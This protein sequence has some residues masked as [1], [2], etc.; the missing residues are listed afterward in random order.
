MH[1]AHP[2]PTVVITKTVTVPAPAPAPSPS[3]TATGTGAASTTSNGTTVAFYSFTMTANYTT[4]LGTTKPTQALMAS[5][6]S[7]ASYDLEFSSE[8][9]ALKVT[10]WENVS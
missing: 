10:L 3:A 7:G 1:A 8:F 6:G 4:P 5:Y 9:G 2:S